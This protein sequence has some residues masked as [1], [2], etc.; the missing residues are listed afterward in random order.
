M[1]SRKYFR[2][3]TSFFRAFRKQKVIAIIKLLWFVTVYQDCVW[4]R[5]LDPDTNPCESDLKEFHE[6]IAS[7][8]KVLS[9]EAT[10][11]AIAHSSPPFPDP[12]ATRH[13]AGS[14]CNAAS[15]LIGCYLLL[16]SSAGVTFLQVFSTELS[17]FIINLKQFVTT[18]QNI[19]INK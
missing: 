3:V 14:L 6:N 5:K 8:S 2:T 19:V 11:F 17:S 12:S 4:L 1:F 13:L 15:Q 7:I 16:P 10:K 9:H 18:I